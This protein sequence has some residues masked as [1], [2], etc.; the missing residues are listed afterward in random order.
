[1]NHKLKLLALLLLLFAILSFFFICAVY[2]ETASVAVSPQPKEV[3][4]K[5]FD[6]TLD[7]DWKI[8]LNKR[9]KE[10][11]FSAEYL[12]NKVCEKY[13]LILILRGLNEKSKEKTISL[14]TSANNNFDYPTDILNKIGQEGYILD[15]S[16]DSIVIIAN[17]SSGVFYGIQT[18]LQLFNSK[19]GIIYIPALEIIDYPEV[20]LR[21]VHFN[22]ANLDNI[23][24][25]LDLIASFKINTAIIENWV[26]FDLD[27]EAN[28]EKLI[29]IFK[30]ARERFIEPV[31][32]VVSFS[33]A[34][35]FLSKNPCTAEGIW[36]RDARFI[37]ED[38]YA[39]P[40]SAKIP[41]LVNII[42][43]K[44]SDVII[45]DK[46]KSKIYRKDRD[47]VI[48]EGIICYPYNLNNSPTKIKRIVSGD[49]KENQEV[50]ISFDYV[51]NITTSW[52]SWSVPYCCS[53]ELT[54]QIIE[55]VYEKVITNLS[56]NYISIG[57]DEIIGMNRD[58]RC[59]RRDLSN[60]ELLGYDINRLNNIAKRLDP[61]IRLMVWDD[62]LN[63]WHNGGD[64]NYQVPFGGIPGKTALA[65]DLIP[66]DIILMVW[67]YENNDR[68]GKMRNSPDYFK[69]K[70]F[71][72]LVAAW[73]E[74][75]NIKDWVKIITER[76]NSKGLV[77]T[78][79][80]GF[81][82]NLENIKLAAELC[83]LGDN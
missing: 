58:S 48:I 6:I 9:D 80:E 66:K 47:Y 25:Q 50:L 82:K 38:D 60:A 15:I 27:K 37:F 28:L 4:M 18:L 69:D 49:I 51:K 16:S 56:P 13:G 41:P 10:N 12:I 32:E 78:T 1:M 20:E 35:P 61:H 31:P 34:T 45:T 40:I 11:L 53:S 73:N 63:P 76:G 21:G 36:I 30:Y 42:G 55:E 59:R 64:E 23:K 29:E 83:W 14:I 19:D 75:K 46:K 62:M 8:V 33:H 54:Y 7:K 74:K 70:E 57:H 26:Y 71:D 77:I 22:A 52:T 44:Q 17:T 24:E 39:R 68:L 72:Y 2:T 67:W 79:W 3:N 81:Q 65:I 5:G 43:T